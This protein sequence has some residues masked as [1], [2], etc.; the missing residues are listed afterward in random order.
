MGKNRGVSIEFAMSAEVTSRNT[1][2]E[3]I[4]S[5]LPPEGDLRETC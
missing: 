4:T 5:A 1:S 3:Q 2:G